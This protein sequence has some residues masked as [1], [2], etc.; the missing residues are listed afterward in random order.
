MNVRINHIL[1]RLVY[2]HCK[3]LLARFSPSVHEP[4]QSHKEALG[5]SCNIWVNVS[6]VGFNLTACKYSWRLGEAELTCC[7]GVPGVHY[8]RGLDC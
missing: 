2:T 6:V 7:G 4:N 3:I 5:L 1:A 8:Y